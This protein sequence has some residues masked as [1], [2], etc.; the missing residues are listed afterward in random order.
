MSV[1]VS[2]DENSIGNIHAQE[3][4]TE[5]RGPRFVVRDTPLENTRR[6]FQ[7]VR[8]L[9]CCIDRLKPAG[10]TLIVIPV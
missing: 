9:S 4:E 6:G 5:V 8:R 10:P 7:P 1:R 3:S 2:Y